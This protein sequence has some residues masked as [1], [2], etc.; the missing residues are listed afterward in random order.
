MNKIVNAVPLPDCCLQIELQDGRCGVFDVK[1]FMKSEYFAQLEN[2]DYFQKVSLFFSGIGW[3]EGQDLGP[4]TVAA[5]L[6]FS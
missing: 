1:P 2:K 5:N 3:P 6:I 4:D